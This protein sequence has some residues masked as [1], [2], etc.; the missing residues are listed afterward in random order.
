MYDSL[1]MLMVAALCG[2]A[3]GV[4]RQWSG[5][6]TG[7]DARFGG[8]RTF[9]LIGGTGGMVG[10]LWMWGS[11]A[12]A[13][14]LATGVVA[15]IAIAYA[16]SSR[17]DIDAT[18]EVAALVVLAAGVAAGLGQMQVASGLA[19]ATALLLF[20]KHRLHGLVSRVHDIELQ[21]ALRFAVMA[22][23]ILPLLPTGGI[24]SQGLIRPRA[25]WL[26]VLVFSAISFLGYI[27][28]RVIGLS[29]GYAVTGL[30]GG[31]VSSTAVTLTFSRLSQR[32]AMDGLAYGIVAAN[33][34]V[35]ARVVVAAAVL[36]PTLALQLAP[37]LSGAALVGVLAVLGSWWRHRPASMDEAHMP[38]PLR[39]PLHLMAAVQMAL[40]FQGVLIV[41]SLAERAG[42]AGLM[43]TA[44]LLGLH[45]VDALTVSMATRVAEGSLAG[46]V[47]WRAVMLGVLSNTV[48]KLVLALTVARGHVRWHASLVLGLMVLLLGA[49]LMMR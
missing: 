27:A 7:P 5:H 43:A 46:G 28:Q 35:Y 25:V 20:E 18:T 6:A 16:A 9:T 32:V 13:L 26:L 24:D 40:L 22:A 47:A 38:E 36:S 10:R 34:V 19:A 49:A 29:R 39:N 17:R 23:V 41:V 42:Q 15:L 8:V 12:L 45:D 11:P 14:V 48:V 21:A 1:L 4:E 30:L 31:L 44:T 2:A 37:S 33:T 3:V